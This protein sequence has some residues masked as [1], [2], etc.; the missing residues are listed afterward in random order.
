MSTVLSKTNRALLCRCWAA[1][2]QTL[3]STTNCVHATVAS[4]VASTLSYL[5][6]SA[7]A[8]ATA[9]PA[10]AALDAVVRS[11]H[12]GIRNPPARGLT[13]EE[14]ALVDDPVD[15]PMEDAEPAVAAVI[16]V[17]D[18]GCQTDPLPSAAAVQAVKPPTS[19]PV[20]EPASK[21]AKLD[22]DPVSVRRLLPNL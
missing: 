19:E 12:P 8:T 20:S 2:T 17:N 10:M 18:Q 15:D 14:A 13:G 1:L 6:R 22:L 16:A 9:R 11:R 5:Q 21:Q 7:G 3:T 4:P